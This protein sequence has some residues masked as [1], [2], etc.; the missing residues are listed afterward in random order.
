[1]KPSNAKSNALGGWRIDCPEGDG[2]HGQGFSS[3]S[4]L[5]VLLAVLR[6][7]VRGTRRVRLSAV[8]HAALAA[9]RHLAGGACVAANDVFPI[10]YGRVG[11]TETSPIASPSTGASLAKAIRPDTR[12]L[13]IRHDPSAMARHI[14]VAVD[15]NGTPHHVPD[16]LGRIFKDRRAPGFVCRVSALTDRGAAALGNNDFPELA[17]AMNVY[18]SEFDQLTG[19]S[20]TSAVAPEM[21]RLLRKFGTSDL[22]WKPS[23][24]G[25]CKSL[26]LVVDDPDRGAAVAR[27]LKELGWQAGLLRLSAGL[28]IKRARSGMRI[29]LSAGHR[30]DLIGAADLGQDVR[31]G[32]AGRCLACA[33]E[34]RTR[35]VLSFTGGNVPKSLQPTSEEAS[36]DDSLHDTAL[37]PGEPASTL[38]TSDRYPG[39]RILRRT[40]WRSGL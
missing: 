32:V 13:P 22:G 10:V 38:R 23:G 4:N 39:R 11:M 8:A 21:K 37:A 35:W 18:R 5:E 17:D 20:F 14:V 34:P 25:A 24:A 6:L 40:C 7:I 3:S 12:Y 2:V 29:D 16:L 28:T 9:E 15:P 36:E 30:I 33:V 27:F 31:V 19:G 1:M 26:I